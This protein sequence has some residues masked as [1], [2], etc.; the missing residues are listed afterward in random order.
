MEKRGAAFCD[1][2]LTIGPMSQRHSPKTVIPLPVQA[3]FRPLGH[4]TCSML[5]FAATMAL[6]AP[7]AGAQ[8]SPAAPPD[9]WKLQQTLG[10]PDG[11]RVEGS[12]R[13]RYEALANPFVSGRP[14]DD[15]FLG[16]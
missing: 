2:F 16:L 4:F 1:D 14:D 15:E 8:G 9:V 11:V 12:V 10:L 7:H 13:P 3:R 6:S 5:A